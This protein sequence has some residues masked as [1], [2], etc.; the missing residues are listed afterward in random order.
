MKKSL[1]I[2]F[3][4][5]SLNLFGQNDREWFVRA[6]G[7]VVQNYIFDGGADLG[8]GV[9]LGYIPSTKTERTWR[10]YFLFGIETIP[11]CFSSIRCNSF[12]YD[13]NLRVQSGLERIVFHSETSK[14]MLGFGASV[15]AGK[16]MTGRY[17][18]ERDGVIISEE[19]DKGFEGAVSP[20][21]SVKYFDKR[22]SEKITFGYAIDWAFVTGNIIHGLSLDWRI[23]AR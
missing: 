9:H 11:F 23:Q 3:L 15:F 7:N 21:F 16:M 5:S 10:P 4:V 18:L 17:T 22:I 1:L 12:W 19:Y 6:N 14:V 8:L 20:Q 13:Y 2:L